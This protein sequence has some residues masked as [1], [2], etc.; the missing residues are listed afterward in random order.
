MLFLS[1]LTKSFLGA[2]AMTNEP[3]SVQIVEDWTKI[4]VA[5]KDPILTIGNFDG[6]HIGHQALFKRVHERALN[7]G[8]E[9]VVLT[10]EP[11]PM[12]VLF[13]EK[14]PPRL[15]TFQQKIH[16]I[17]DFG[18]SHIICIKF[19][20][21]FAGISAKDF[22]EKLLVGHLKIKEL[23][24]GY[25]YTFGYKREGNV[26]IL[27]EFGQRLG[28]KV[29]VIKGI[30]VFGEMVSSTNIR[31]HIIEGDLE[32]AKRLIGR[33]YQ[34]AGKVI[35]GAGRGGKLL[36]FPTANIEPFNEVIPKEGVY[37][38][39]V[40]YNGVL[41]DG[42]TNIGRNPTFNEQKISIETH[43]FNFYKD[44]IGEI[45]KLIFIKRLREEIKFSSPEE[46]K[47]QIKKD[48]RRAKRILHV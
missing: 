33:N 13:P 24:V 31:R 22:V 8:G 37:A 45:L 42:V 7:T 9:G 3:N 25:N 16:L 39:H 48:I 27:R 36:G 44:I 14:A 35:K 34:I 10:F 38:V 30:K 43:I 17:Q 2:E 40:L 1:R 20:H 47:A 19:T 15:T 5:F 11:H 4:K 29:H 46:L 28:F 18:I 21:A 26:D 23:V 32:K 41:Y 6:L 12:A